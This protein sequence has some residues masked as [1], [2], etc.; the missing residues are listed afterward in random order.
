M[1]YCYSNWDRE[2][3]CGGIE[4]TCA[5]CGKVISD[6]EWISHWTTCSECFNAHIDDYLKESESDSDR[7]LQ[8]MRKNKER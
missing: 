4:Q 6:C 1:K 2:C 5:K 3:K 7:Q 8:K